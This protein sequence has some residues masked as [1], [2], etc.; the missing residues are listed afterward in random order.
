MRYQDV[1][2]DSDHR[3][4]QHVGRSQ[5]T[6]APTTPDARPPGSSGDPAPKDDSEKRNL[7]SRLEAAEF[8]NQVLT[9]TLQQQQRAMNPATP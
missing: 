3:R 1:D 5:K 9:S 2:E 8:K 7:R 6:A 4:S